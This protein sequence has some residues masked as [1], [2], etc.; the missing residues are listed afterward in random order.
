MATKKEITEALT[1]ANVEFDANAT[2]ADLEAI[3][4]EHEAGDQ[5]KGS[6]SAVPKKFKDIYK[7]SNNS[8][9]DEMARHLAAV[10][11]GPNGKVDSGALNKVGD[12]N[13]IDVQARWGG[14]N[15]G[16]QRMNLGNVLRNMIRQGQ[17]VQVGDQ[18]W[19]PA[20]EAAA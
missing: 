17:R 14:R 18:V 2:K 13:G 12:Q 6:N 10:V 20:E 5:P 7:K 16:M 15:V 1:A 8:C 19:E 9:G 11:K 4:A 3:L